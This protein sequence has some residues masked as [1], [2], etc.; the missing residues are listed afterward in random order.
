M[1]G[2]LFEAEICKLMYLGP[3]MLAVL[4]KLG[5]LPIGSQYT[6][7]KNVSTISC[8]KS[9]LK[10]SP[11]S[12][13]IANSGIWGSTMQPVLNKLGCLSIGPKWTNL[14]FFQ[15]IPVQN[16]NSMRVFGGINWHLVYLGP[17]EAYLFGLVYAYGLAKYGRIK[18]LLIISNFKI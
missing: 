13:K 16:I 10:G 3:T 14:D 7:L 12:E 17:C 8:P 2:G 15:Q 11:F 18:T 1:K 4:D 9:K 5:C 6:N